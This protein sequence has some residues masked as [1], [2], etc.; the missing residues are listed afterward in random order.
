MEMTGNYETNS[1]FTTFL[2]LSFLV[3]RY[4]FVTNL[5]PIRIFLICIDLCTFKTRT[6]L[7]NKLF[8]KYKMTA[9][10]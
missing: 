4:E 1:D 8:A 6:Y 3:L 7:S 10:K 2:E 9:L 5:V